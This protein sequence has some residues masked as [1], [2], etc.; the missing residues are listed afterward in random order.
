M[1][2]T[3]KCDRVFS[4][5]LAKSEQKE[6]YHLLDKLMQ[7]EAMPN[8]IDL[9]FKQLP[10]SMRVGIYIKFIKDQKDLNFNFYEIEYNYRRIKDSEKATES[11]VNIFNEGFNKHHS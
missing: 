3:G 4:D 1:E 10:A 6:V 11:T 5:W 9:T 2:L 7:H 8:F